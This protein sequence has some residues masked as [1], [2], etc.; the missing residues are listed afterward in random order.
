M[1]PDE[2][3]PSS[4]SRFCD[5]RWR[6]QVRWHLTTWGYII[7]S[8]AFLLVA[9]NWQV[10]ETLSLFSFLKPTHWS[11]YYMSLKAW[12]NT[13]REIWLICSLIYTSSTIF[14]FC[15]CGRWLRG[16]GFFLIPFSFVWLWIYIFLWHYRVSLEMALL[17][18]DDTHPQRGCLPLNCPTDSLGSTGIRGRSFGTGHQSVCML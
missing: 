14:L 9:A 13:A 3:Y 7:D 16:D 15:P 17:W 11:Q 6:R 5:W 1:Q 12:Q 18:S 2:I 8:R 10:S 4:V